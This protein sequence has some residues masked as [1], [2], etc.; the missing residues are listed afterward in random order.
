MEMDPEEKLQELKECKKKLAKLNAEIA[1]MVNIQGVAKHLRTR[2]G[3]NL[4]AALLM[5]VGGLF[6]L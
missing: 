4:A 5:L 3:L 6:L 2:L 1:K